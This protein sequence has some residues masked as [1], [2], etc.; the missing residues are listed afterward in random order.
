MSL[1]SDKRFRRPHRN[2]NVENA[3][4]TPTPSRRGTNTLATTKTSRSPRPA[5]P[6]PVHA[7]T[8]QNGGPRAVCWGA[9]PVVYLSDEGDLAV[10]VVLPGAVL[11]Q[12]GMRKVSA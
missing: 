10:R 7:R 3:P 9:R 1:D 6:P 8:R 12:Q 11:S 5:S 4:P 2:P